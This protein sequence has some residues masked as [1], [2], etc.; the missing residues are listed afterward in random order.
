MNKLLVAA[1]AGAAMTAQAGILTI[2]TDQ[3]LVRSAIG[4]D[5][6][7]EAVH[8]DFQIPGDEAVYIYDEGGATPT[9]GLGTYGVVGWIAAQSVTMPTTITVGGIGGGFAMNGFSDC[10]VHIEIQTDDGAGAPS[11][12]VL[13]TTAPISLTGLPAYPGYIVGKGKLTPRV[14]M[15]RGQTYHIVYHADV[16]ANFVVGAISGTFA[17]GNAEQ[18]LDNGVSWSQHAS[19]DLYFGVK[20]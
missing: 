2:Q 16:N 15:S 4:N 5:N 6:Y 12:T 8:P 17:Y 11:G 20:Y 9:Q 7:V 14:T 1:L 19:T 18:T 10:T 3:G 13:G